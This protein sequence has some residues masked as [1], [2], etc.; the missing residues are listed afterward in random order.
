MSHQARQEIWTLSR[1]LMLGRQ[2]PVTWKRSSVPGGTKTVASQITPYPHQTWKFHA[3]WRLLKSDTE[4]SGNVL[5]NT[6]VR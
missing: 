4:V 5:R 1:E 3:L 2:D 6:R